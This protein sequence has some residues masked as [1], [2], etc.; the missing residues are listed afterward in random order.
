M[1]LRITI[2][3]TDE[4]EELYRFIQRTAHE[5][6]PER[7]IKNALAFYLLVAS[8]QIKDLDARFL[9]RFGSGNEQEY[10]DALLDRIRSASRIRAVES[11]LQPGPEDP[12]DPSAA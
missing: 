7:I 3:L 12:T 4:Q 5:R 11:P 9:V 8:A 10:E 1:A 6:R 2:E